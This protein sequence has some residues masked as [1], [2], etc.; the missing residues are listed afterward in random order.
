MDR[1][2][3]P[4][5]L[6]W[7]NHDIV[8]EFYREAQILAALG[9]KPNLD[10]QVN[11]E[12]EAHLV[13]EPDNPFDANAISVRINGNVV[14]YLERPVAAEYRQVIHRIT[15][16]GA[17]ATT[18]AS[19]WAV[20]RKE[21]DWEN[22]KDSLQFH[23]NIRV[24]LPA[25]NQIM[26]LNNSSISGVA[27]LP[28][29]GALQVTGEDKHFDHLFNYVPAT[30]EGMVILT[31]HRLVQTLKNGNEKELVEVRL[32]GER[33]GQLTAATSPHYLQTIRH[34]EDMG[35]QL[36]I[37]AKL[38]GSGL[39]AE[40]VIQGARASDLSDEWLRT[41]PEIPQL[42]PEAATYPVPPAFTEAER[43]SQARRQNTIPDAEPRGAQAGE[44]ATS[45]PSRVA[46]TPAS[47]Q[48]RVGKRLIPISDKDRQHTPAAH[49]A[50]GVAMIIIGLVLGALLAAIPVIGPILTL[51]LIGFGIYGN[52]V[53]RRVASALEAERAA[54]SGR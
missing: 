51:A 40:L 19:V 49:R 23:C 41:M 31:M 48:V 22:N 16:S 35:K 53:K 10:E 13:P 20:R 26:P 39:A 47:G 42:V 37:W 30:G 21:W 28:W 27:V 7:A 54:V 15:A 2:F 46:A 24:A 9:R 6:N 38:K 45:R 50:A 33:V 29:G 52:V 1:Y 17:V 8:G 32:D 36:G 12:F 11:E 14:G 34:A 4:G 5:N 3:L 25:V 43:A 18:R 44:S